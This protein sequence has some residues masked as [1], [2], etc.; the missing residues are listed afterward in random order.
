MQVGLLLCDHVRPEFAHIAGDYPDMFAALLEGR[1]ITLRIYDLP[2]G[3]FPQ[4]LAECAGWIST[5]SRSS[6]YDDE[7]WIEGFAHLVKG[8]QR[9]GR[10]FVGI[11]FG[12]QMIGHALGGQVERSSRGWGVGVK[13]VEV[14]AGE[15]WM[16]PPAESFKV[17]NSHQDQI[18]RL[19]PG[20]R[21]LGS[22]RHCPVAML[23]VGEHL[24]GIQG[25]PEF[26]P[27]YSRALMEYRRGWLIPDEVV[28]A[29]LA[30]LEE[31]AD[32][33][34]LSSWIVSFLTADSV[35]V[36]DSSGKEGKV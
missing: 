7:R 8:C 4:T 28:E 22:S 3:Q 26:V 31:P 23:A 18:E 25:H 32:T 20:A 12:A 36:S 14:E 35:R 19:P 13:R 34:L 11:C 9:E 29:G 17:L 27:E 10:P 30:S 5:G 16:D 6:V 15:S 24:L 2:A 33:A 1:G 21:V